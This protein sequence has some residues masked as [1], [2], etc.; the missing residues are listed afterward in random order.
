MTR[1]HLAELY[2][3][4][5]R[6]F[7]GLSPLERDVF[8]LPDLDLYYE[9][10]GGVEDYILSGGH[11][12]ELSW[13]SGTLARI[14]D[15]ESA[16]AIAELRQLGETGRAATSPLCDRFFSRREQHRDLMLD[17]LRGHDAELEE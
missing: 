5:L 7:G 14:D 1:L 13:L 8:V 6:D 10:E 9:M 17:H 3:R 15:R 11:E 12:A 16:A 2:E 4:G